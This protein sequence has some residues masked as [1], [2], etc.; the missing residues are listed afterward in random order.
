M[1]AH[2]QKDDLGALVRISERQLITARKLRIKSRAV[3]VESE[4][5]LSSSCLGVKHGK[6]Q[7]FRGVEL[8]KHPPKSQNT[9]PH[10]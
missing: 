1:R 7:L 8:E 4:L 5:Q 3:V 2:P 9:L 6:E 10:A